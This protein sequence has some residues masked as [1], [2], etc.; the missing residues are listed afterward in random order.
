MTS[1]LLDQGLPHSAAALLRERG[2][3]ALHVAD[4]SLGEAPDHVILAKAQELGRIVCTLDSDFHALMALSGAR[5]PSV[6]L[7]RIQGLKAPQIVD[8]LARIIGVAEALIV[9][10]A[11]VTATPSGLRVRK[12]PLATDLSRRESN[13][14]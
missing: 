9:G 6:I 2:F 1:L 11:L 4:L 3:D 8:L 5:K 7:I 12:L 14:H 10:G 13:E